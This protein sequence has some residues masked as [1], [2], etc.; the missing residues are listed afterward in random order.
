MSQWFECKLFIKRI[1]MENIYQS[2]IQAIENGAK[3]Q[4][5]F[6]QRSLKLD[7]KYIIKNGEY[8]GDLGVKACDERECLSEME[9]LYCRYK[10][11]VPSER[12]ESK[13]RQ[14]FKALPERDLDDDSM[15]FGERRDKAQV[16]LE[17]YLLCQIINGFKWNTETMGNWFWQSQNDKDLVI[18]RQWVESV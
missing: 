12:S 3:F 2:T 7:G 5:N 11:S 15:M 9:M 8:E 1:D 4:V 18:L 14:Y 13:S 10:Y 17:L 6:Q 16:E